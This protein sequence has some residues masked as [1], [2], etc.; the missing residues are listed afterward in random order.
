MM[1][2]I[3]TFFKEKLGQDILLKNSIAIMTDWTSCLS[4]AKNVLLS[5]AV[6]NMISIFAVSVRNT[7]AKIFQITKQSM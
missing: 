1:T 2:T 6:N 4:F 5:S 7:R 3:S